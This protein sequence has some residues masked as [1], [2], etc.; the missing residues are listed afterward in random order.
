MNA[1]NFSQV[2]LIVVA[3]V[4]VILA[5]GLGFWIGRVT[6]PTRGSGTPL[7]EGLAPTPPPSP[8][9][10]LMPTSSGEDSVMVV[11]QT[12]GTRVLITSVEFA[13]DGWVVVHENAS[14]KPGRILGA[15]RFI[16]GSYRDVSV[17][18]LRATDA[19]AKYSAMLHT[20]DGD[21]LFDTAKDIPVIDSAGMLIMANF[22]TLSGAATQ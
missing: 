4:I 19:G 8:A 13:K 14:G 1:K 5:G 6:L 3:T 18:L 21:H 10:N 2:Q 7:L 22:R 15:Q 9:A 16:A 12:A 11:D 20:D 17:D